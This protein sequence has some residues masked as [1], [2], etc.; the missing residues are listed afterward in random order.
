MNKQNPY[1]APVAELE[2]PGLTEPGIDRIA[3][4][5]KLVI[6]SILTYFAAMA[7]RAFMGPVGVVVLLAALVMGLVGSF[8]L[9]SSLGYSTLVKVILMVLMLVPLVSLL[10]LLVLNRK[11]TGRLRAAGYRVGLLGA[12][13]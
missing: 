2:L 12:S 13:R 8:R 6:Y 10:V 9:C 7:I 5:Q 1:S 4:A 3:S 11:A